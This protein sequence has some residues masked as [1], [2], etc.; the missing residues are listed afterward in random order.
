MYCYFKLFHF[1]FPCGINANFNCD[2]TNYVSTFMKLCN[3]LSTQVRQ[4]YVA[5]ER[6]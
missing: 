5:E 1:L 6:R 4:N 2:R 3:V